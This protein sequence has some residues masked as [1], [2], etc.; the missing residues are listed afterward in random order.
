MPQDAVLA[1]PLDRARQ[2]GALELDARLQRAGAVMFARDGRS[3]AGHYGSVAAELAVCHKS[4]GLAVRSDVQTLL[5]DGDEAWLEQL[6]ERALGARVPAAGTAGSVAGGWCARVQRERALVVAR[7]SALAS[8]RRM[9]REAVITGSRVATADESPHELAMSLLG[10]RTRE[11]LRLVGLPAV[12]PHRV[13]GGRLAG[14]EAMLLGAGGHHVLVVMP[15]PAPAACELLLDA[16]RLV[17]LS[18]V[19]LDAIARL[20]ATQTRARTRAG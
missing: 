9:I 17:G 19:G 13:E 11:L 6:L 3:V 2:H 15:Y 14:T 18:L 16:G 8:W 12:A 20:T 10:P 4:V 1:V 7:P 5:L